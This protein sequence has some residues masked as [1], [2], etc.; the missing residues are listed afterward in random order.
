[1]SNTTKTTRIIMYAL[2]GLVTIALIIFYMANAFYLPCIPLVVAIAI[3]IYVVSLEVKKDVSNERT[4]KVSA[5]YM[6]AALLALSMAIYALQREATL[7]VTIMLF[8]T[9][10]VLLYGCYDDY[11]KHN[12]D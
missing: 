4:K 12:D 1:M 3:I 5:M 9:V 8:L 10:P 6:F 2:A 11:K 7:T